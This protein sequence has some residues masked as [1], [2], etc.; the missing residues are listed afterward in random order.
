MKTVISVASLLACV[1]SLDAQITYTLNHLPDGSDEVSIRN[2]SAT[3]L[4]AWVIAGKRV[5][6][7]PAS[8]G[9]AAGLPP[10]RLAASAPND[11]I[12]T[13]SPPSAS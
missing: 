5:T 9:A 12:R 1:F 8:P 6:Q 13:P 2:N 3:S 7:S 10:A 11:I 4:V